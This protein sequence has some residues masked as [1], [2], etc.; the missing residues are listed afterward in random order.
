MQPKAKKSKIVFNLNF[1]TSKLLS[2]I[3]II[4]SSIVGYLLANAEIIIIGL[5]VGGALSGAKSVSDN[6]LKLKSGKIFDDSDDDTKVDTTDADPEPETED[7]DKP[8]KK[9]KKEIL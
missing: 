9:K 1:T 4:L 6:I 3:V 8:T 5:I 2:Y 7:V